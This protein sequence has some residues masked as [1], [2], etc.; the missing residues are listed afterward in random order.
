MEDMRT[1]QIRHAGNL[2]FRAAHWPM[3]PKRPTLIFIH[4]SGQSSLFWQAQ[5]TILANT[6]N[7]LAID[8]PGHGASPGPA[9]G[10]VKA[11]AK[12][13]LQFV[14]AI[15][16]SAPIVCGL[17]LGGA[18]ILSLL[19]DD[20][21]QFSAGILVNTGARLRV[22]PALFDTIK[23][24]FHAYLKLLP[25]FGLTAANRT[26]SEMLQKIID[27]TEPSAE[28]ATLDF[29]ACNQFDVMA[30]LARIKVPVLVLAATE[31]L[32]TPSKYAIYL[33][34]Q[35][36]DAELFNIAGA[37]HLSPLE[38]PATV[39]AAIADFLRRRIK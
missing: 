32:L 30:D 5:I 1:M 23:T 21:G 34:Q 25:E 15:K 29:Q 19:I 31:D 22:M 6:C 16:A 4:G 26:N 18:I 17:S 36:P 37:G 35:I 7:A 12:A 9:L 10:D 8:L 28:V 38:Q 27:C 24:D 13:V 14:K 20:P 2:A 11:Y 33:A 39:S 3:D